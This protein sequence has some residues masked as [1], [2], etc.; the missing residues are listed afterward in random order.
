MTLQIN[1]SYELL[2]I[3]NLK[4]YS[5][6]AYDGIHTAESIVNV[7]ILDVNNNV[8]QFMQEDYSVDILEDVAIG[9]L[10]L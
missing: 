3:D 6:Q 2:F 7:Q 8:P 9:K 1:S 5:F 10:R 4:K